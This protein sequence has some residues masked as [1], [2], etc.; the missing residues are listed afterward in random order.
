MASVEIQSSLAQ[1]GMDSEGFLLPSARAA[2]KLRLEEAA[3]LLAIDEE[4]AF[5]LDRFLGISGIGH[6]KGLE[7]S[8]TESRQIFEELEEKLLR[9]LPSTKD[10]IEG[11]LIKA[12]IHSLCEFLHSFDVA[13]KMASNGDLTTDQYLR[14]S[15][16]LCSLF[17]KV[18][19]ACEAILELVPATDT[20]Q[21]FRDLIQEL[22]Y[23]PERIEGQRCLRFELRE[24]VALQSGDVFGLRGLGRLVV[25]SKAE[26]GI[27]HCISY[28]YQSHRYDALSVLES[29]VYSAAPI[30][31]RGGNNDLHFGEEPFSAMQPF[32]ER[33]HIEPSPLS[34]GREDYAFGEVLRY[35]QVTGNLSVLWHLKDGSARVEEAAQSDVRVRGEYSFGMAGASSV[36]AKSSF[37]ELATLG[38]LHGNLPAQRDYEGRELQALCDAVLKAELPIALHIVG[39]EWAC[40]QF[41]EVN[42]LSKQMVRVTTG[43]LPKEDPNHLRAHMCT[44]VLLVLESLGDRTLTTRLI[45]LKQ[46]GWEVVV[47]QGHNDL[48]EDNFIK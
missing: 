35:S 28:S 25:L 33:V 24:D 18:V 48:V 17:E 6:G 44:P 9:L 20:P 27:L 3:P 11:L 47:A 43:A 29:D 4:L 23:L 38:G 42:L 21:Y 37:K 36:F 16:Y 45:R 26:G 5:Q 41:E 34:S 32:R 15:S 30:V 8:F 12:K 39:E 7:D 1:H 10:S 40:S 46:L 14:T 19:T 13:R 31:S 2:V 22:S